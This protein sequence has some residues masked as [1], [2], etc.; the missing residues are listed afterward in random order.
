MSFRG[1]LED[2]DA[3]GLL[4]HVHESVSPVQE[5]TERSWGK[6]PILFDNVSGHKCCLNIL[7]TRDLLARALG[8]APQDMV[9]HLSEIGYQGPVRE[10]DWSPFMEKVSRPDL[11]SLPIL[12]Y[13]PGDGGP[14][15]TSGVVSSR[16]EGRI[17]ACVHRL[18]VLG[19]DRLAARLVPGRHT[20]QFYESARSKGEEVPVAVAIGVDPLVLMAASTRVP[21]EMEFQYAAALRGSPVEL[22]P[23]E[24]GVL[25]PHAEIV[26]EGYITEERAPEGPF[27]DITGTR[28]LVRQEPVI[29]ITKMMMRN[30][31]IYH[32]LLPAGGE[33]K[34]LM[35]VPYE[36]LIYRAVSKV[37]KIK[38][39][40]LTEGGCCYFHAVVQIEKET[41][42][43]AKRAID[44]TINAHGSLKHVLVV[45]SDINIHDP[46]DLEYALATRMRGDEDIVLY[47]NVRGSTLDPRSNEGMTTKVGVDATARLD[48]LWKFQRVTP[49]GQG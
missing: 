39:V 43:D 34:M 8:V 13:F 42:Q 9:R 38:D 7:G 20:H 25:V 48:R 18:M 14:Y 5:V 40:L 17:N 36:P 11:T 47:P 22:V 3:A 23:L 16:F 45:D 24:N 15:I 19:K 44:A 28:D 41:E 35:G 6:G 46:R 4:N 2:L 1:F 30:E 33:H 29:R 12:T 31:S 10:V 32:G 21:P 26:L 27:V 49:P 37:A